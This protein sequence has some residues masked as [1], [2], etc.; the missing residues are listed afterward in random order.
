MHADLLLAKE[1]L[2]DRFGFLLSAFAAEDESKGY[3]ACTFLLDER[4]VKFRTANITPTKTGQFVTLWKRNAEG[5]TA[6]HDESDPY[7]LYVIGARKEN[8]VGQFVFPKP[9][10]LKNGI[11]SGPHKEGKR[12]FRVYAPWDVAPAGQAQKTQK[13]QS[14]FFIE[15]KENTDRERVA[16][17]Y[18]SH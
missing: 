7:A 13:W 15:L 2:Y 3:G 12:G 14:E 11:L 5:V 10:L 6:P 8:L 16:L 18:G 9:A 17:L 1:Q 4:P